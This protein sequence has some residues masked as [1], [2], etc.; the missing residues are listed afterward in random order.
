MA[1]NEYADI[2]IIGA[3]LAGIYTALNLDPKLSVVV[4]SKEDIKE[5]NSVLAQGGIAAKIKEDDEFSLHMEDTL[6]AGS[7]LNKQDALATLVTEGPED[8]DKLIN[9][10]VE[11]DKDEEGNIQ[12]TMEGGHSRRR[13]LHAGG[14]ATGREII[15]ALITECRNRKNI[16][17]CENTMAIDLIIDNNKCIGVKVLK[18]DE[19]INYYSSAC[20]LAAGGI[21]SVYKRSTNSAV[22]TGDGVAIAYRGGAEIDN[23]EFVQFHPTAFYSKNK[24]KKFLISEAVRGEGA[25]LRT[26]NGE[27]FMEKYHKDLE[28]APRDVVSQSIYKEIKKSDSDFVYLDIT[29][30]DKE[31]LMR[32]FPTIYKECL[33]N[34]IDISKDYIPVAPVEHY[35]IG[36]IST[37]INGIC[38]LESLYAAGEN[39]DSGVH[40]ANRLASNSLLECV[41]FG[42][43]VAKHIN[44]NIKLIDINTDK[45]DNNLNDTN[46]ITINFNIDELKEIIRDT[47]DKYVG[48]VRKKSELLK[49]KEIIEDILNKVDFN[50]ND[51][52]FYE[53]KNMATVGSL[54]IDAC[55]ER[56]KSVGCH[57]RID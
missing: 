16:T 43:R 32:R 50:Y 26:T 5:N 20:V 27:R 38:I 30:R 2:V 21:G 44:E 34:D 51:K 46:E 47:M 11:F 31:Y 3:G 53:L 23:M 19:V 29:H 14:D 13:I 33:K 37:D 22:A 39:A 7:N 55:I 54:I 45:Y 52:E 35:S 28:L 18:N 6:K 48:I 25:F 24:G 17:L 15:K 42:R 8:I 10:G 57:Y 40:G 36:G 4:L 9:L 56:E 12:T 41:V 1:L 49:A